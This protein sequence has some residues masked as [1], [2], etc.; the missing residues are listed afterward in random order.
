MKA[1]IIGGTSGIGK[2]IFDNIK[3]TCSEIKITGRKEL[4][5]SS[6]VS[7][8]FIKRYQK[9]KFDILVLKGGPPDIN[10]FKISDKI[11]I[12]NFNKLFLSFLNLIKGLRLNKKG[13]IFLISSFIIKE[14]DQSLIISSSLRSG[15]VNLFKSLS[16]LFSKDQ[17]CFINLAP[18]PIM[19]KRL[20][21]LLKSEK[22]TIKSFSKTLPHGLVPHPDEIG[23]FVKFVIENR[24]KSFN[25]VTITF[26][27]GLLKG[28]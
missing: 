24:I 21:N 16:K 15:F 2:S 8:K 26:D 4:D 10:F 7:V 12:E 17:I 1:L 27:S 25:G 5:T 11:W 28:V 19:T 14:P 23:L 9:E 20:K 18:G 6:M 22:K 3:S 13:Y